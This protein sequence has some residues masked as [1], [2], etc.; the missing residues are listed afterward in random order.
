MPHMQEEAAAKVE[1]ASLAEGSP[2]TIADIAY[3]PET[4]SDSPRISSERNGLIASS[5][6]RF[7]ES[8]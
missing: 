8:H 3:C 7:D 6:Q 1:A 4:R 5:M 2:V